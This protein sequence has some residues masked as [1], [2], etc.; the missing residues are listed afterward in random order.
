MKMKKSQA[1]KRIEDLRNIIDDYRYHYHV[2]DES[3]MSEA[4]ADSLKHELTLLE[5]EYPEFITPDS[6]TQ[7]VAGKALDKF[8]KVKHEKR[9]ISL[10]DVFND[11][12]I[13]AWRDRMLKVDSSIKDQYYCDIKMDGLACSLIYRDGKLEKAVTRGDGFI[14]EDVTLNV[15]TIHNV[16]LKLRKDKKDENFLVGRTE[17]R[18]EIVMLKSDFD[19]LNDLRRKQGEAIYANPRNL[20]AGTIRQLDPSIV[21]KRPLRFIGYD[22]LRDDM[23]ELSSI[24]EGYEI[25]KDLGFETSKQSKVVNGLREVFKYIDYLGSVRKNLDFNTDGAVIKLNSRS[26]Y[27]ALGIV[28]KTPRAAVAYKFAAEEATTKILDIVISIGRTGAAT[29]VA[30]FEPVNLA[31]T[32]IKHASLHN[33]DEIK[34]LDIRI[35]DTVVI[36]KAGDI[37]PQVQSVILGLRKED[38][39][40]FDFEAELK[41]QYKELEFIRPKGEAVYRVKGS[42]SKIIL[43]RSLEH[44]ASKG[45]LDIDTLGEKNVNVLVDTGLVKDLA[46][47][48]LLK[49]K[50]LLSLERFGDLSSSKLIEAIQNKK[51]IDAERFL[52]GLGIRHVGIQTA[53]DLFNHY[54]TLDE[55]KDTSL[56]EL[57]TVDGIGKVVSESI[58]AWFSD[59]D[60]QKLLE[61]FKDLGVRLNYRDTNNVKL[62]GVHFVVT[63]KLETMSRD[64][65]KDL[66][67]KNGGIFQSAVSKD[68]NYLV[69]GLNTGKSKL[70]KASKLGTK[71]IDESE[72]IKI[73]E[74]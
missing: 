27:D 63:G 28:G 49:K 13:K 40:P 47:I 39:K 70:D 22:L 10:A 26:K 14:G 15:R 68:T 1:K 37:I 53:V 9:M 12:E 4:V 36:Y 67:I 33:A 69:A 19:H 72:F 23:R 34:R 21:A 24:S 73:L 64:E 11:N 29:P 20:A 42:D 61:K 2:L 44:F 32:T 38:S 8:E 31:G 5:E 55:I 56:E 16:P 35:G 65:A 59:E 41:R 30:V 54:K 25:M 17:V 43:K 57:M 18:G 60:N 74:K 66:I 50:D 48:Y 7:R 51:Q 3:T 58:I 52:Y 6:P 71:V 46:D 45:A 62:K